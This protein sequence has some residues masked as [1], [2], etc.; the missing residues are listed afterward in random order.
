MSAKKDKQEEQSFEQIVA[1]LENIA[2]TLETGDTKLEDALSLFEEGVR[3][4]QEGTRRL[5]AAEHRL[6]VLLEDDKTEPFEPTSTDCRHRW[7]KCGR[8]CWLW[9][10]G[11]RP[12]AHVRKL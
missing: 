9:S 10:R 11:S 6:E 4:S 1:R 7:Q 2:Q 12:H 5:D 3:L 8:I